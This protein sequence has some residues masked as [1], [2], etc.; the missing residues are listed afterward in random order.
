[1]RE[2]RLAVCPEFQERYCKRKVAAPTID[3]AVSQKMDLFDRMPRQLSE[4]G[5]TDLLR[6]QPLVHSL[7][8]YRYRRID[9]AFLVKPAR[10]GDA[11]ELAA[12]VTAK[13]VLLTVAFEDPEILQEHLRLCKKYV[14]HDLHIVG[15]NSRDLSVVE[16]NL[17][18]ADANGARHILL[19]ENPWTARNAG[20]RS[21][22]AAMN[23]LWRN[24]LRPGH[25]KAFG[26]LDHDLFPTAPDAPYALL[27]NHDFHGDQRS[28]GVRWFLWAGYCFFNFE[29]IKGVDLDFGLDWFAGLDTGGANFEVLYKHADRATLPLREIVVVPALDG[30]EISRACFEWRGSWIHEVG[31]STDPACRKAKREA[32]NRILKPYLE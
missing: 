19:P 7:K 9:A 2:D 14:S 5:M 10:G 30:V 26:F 31:W 3:I 21:H 25:P 13:N 20:S 27:E 24:I 32:L 6:L 16:A 15:D 1:M 28:A 22:G 12:A 23:W 29:A 4:Y 17:R 11:D 18:V 8:E